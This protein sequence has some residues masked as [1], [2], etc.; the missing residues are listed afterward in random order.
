[1]SRVGIVS[2][3]RDPGEVLRTFVQYHRSIGFSDFIILF[4]DPCDSD[5]ALASTLEGVTAVA[6]DEGVRDAWRSLR[7]YDQCKDFVDNT[8]GARQLLN[9]EYGF[10][11][12]MEMG[13]EWLLHIDIDE[14]FFIKNGDVISHVDALR[15][16]GK[17]AAA[18]HNY[19]AV[20]LTFDI[21]NYF[22]TVRYFKK[23]IPLLQYQKIKRKDVWPAG[24]RYFNFYNNGKGMTR[25]FPGVYPLG[26]HRWRHDDG[27]L[28]KV[29]FY[30]PAILHYSVC[31]YRYFEQK[32]RHRGNF[33]D[34]RMNKDMRRNGATLDLDARDAYAAN[35]ANLAR[36]IY[37]S[38][39]MMEKE[40]AMRLEKAGILRQF[41]IQKFLQ[42]AP[43]N[44]QG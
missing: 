21:D 20:P 23:P 7:C 9:I 2:M 14:L 41:N 44:S 19:E 3:M 18:Y 4:D 29:T 35:D 40:E 31:G 42:K 17:D 34:V 38:R 39:V 26:A 5:I 15:E 1:M 30:N 36:D 6:V 33:S 10:N 8:V 16:T 32:Y 28:N 12:A 43:D 22:Q 13:V 37:R 27:P 24:R 25:V 11:L